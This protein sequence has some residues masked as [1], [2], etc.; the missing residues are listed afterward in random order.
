MIQRSARPAGLPHDQ[1]IAGL[2]GRAQLFVLGPVLGGESRCGAV[3]VG[4]DIAEGESRR[5]RGRFGQAE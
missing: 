4:Q 3:V 1:H 2:K 5:A